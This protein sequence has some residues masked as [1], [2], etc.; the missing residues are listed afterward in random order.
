MIMMN[1]QKSYLL[2][3]VRNENLIS[4]SITVNIQIKVFS[5]RYKTTVMFMYMIFS[6]NL[7]N[8]QIPFQILIYFSRQSHRY[9]QNIKHEN[10]Q[11]RLSKYFILY[12]FLVEFLIILIFF[13]CE[14]SN[15]LSLSHSPSLIFIRYK[16]NHFIR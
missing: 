13:L 7:C 14:W 12:G 1:K 8:K 2:F 6:K 9:T 5:M 16:K 10:Q 11:N 15:C 4:H 3:K